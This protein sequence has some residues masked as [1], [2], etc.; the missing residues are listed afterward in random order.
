V[1]VI[2]GGSSSVYSGSVSQEV[3]VVDIYKKKIQS[4]ISLKQKNLKIIRL[5]FVFSLICFAIFSGT[6][7]LIF[8]SVSNFTFT[9]SYLVGIVNVQSIVSKILSVAFISH[10]NHLFVYSTDP[11]TVINPNIT[12]VNSTYM[13]REEIKTHFSDLSYSIENF[14]KLDPQRYLGTNNS[15]YNFMYSWSDWKIGSNSTDQMTFFNYLKTLSVTLD[16]KMLYEAAKFNQ[17]SLYYNIEY[18]IE[19][20]YDLE[21]QV[22]SEFDESYNFM[23]EFLFYFILLRFI[24]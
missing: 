3:D 5:L 13:F 18:L 24:K 9:E 11:L 15:I 1:D 2:P 16:E 14:L 10:F 12:L 22:K 23:A 6:L 19:K 17:S 4:N 21:G 7:D 8:T 20:F